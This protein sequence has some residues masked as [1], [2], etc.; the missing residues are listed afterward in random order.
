MEDPA[1]GQ[2][3]VQ[4]FLVLSVLLGT[5]WPV[6]S[7]YLFCT[8]K[9]FFDRRNSAPHPAHLHVLS[10]PRA[11]AGPQYCLQFITSTVLSRP[12][13]V[14]NAILSAWDATA[15]DLLDLHDNFS[16][17]DT[18]HGRH[19]NVLANIFQISK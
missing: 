7:W 1:L 2:A 4:S 9:L 16:E 8:W 3:L 17:T 5:V 12:P 11:Y 10:P 18:P 19:F 13:A 15:L 14:A 6:G